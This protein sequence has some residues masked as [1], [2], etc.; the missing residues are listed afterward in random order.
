MTFT[1]THIHRQHR[2][3]EFGCFR[4]RFQ[5]D[6]SFAEKTSIRKNAKKISYFKKKQK[7]RYFMPTKLGF[8][9]ESYKCQSV[10]VDIDDF[11]HFPSM[12]S[13]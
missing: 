5:S 8:E 12:I 10:E 3:R 11:Y 9:L 2:I 13:Y 7:I 4:Y 1:H 6:Y